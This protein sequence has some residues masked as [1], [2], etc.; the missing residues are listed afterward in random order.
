MATLASSVS[1]RFSLRRSVFGVRR[2]MI[3]STQMS[4]ITVHVT[5][6]LAQR[7]AGRQERLT[8]ILELGL[9]ELNAETQRGF[10]GAAE[11]LEFLAGLPSP[12]EILALRPSESFE[13]RVRE[14]LAKN[15]A[16]G[17]TQQEEEEW[18]RYEYLEHLVRMAKAKAALRLGQPV[19]NG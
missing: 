6:D 19:A 16:S 1:Y 10:V 18:D 17:L 4:A 9:R 2:R 12:Q 7:L 15:R 8:E 14:L 13:R 3:Y 5:D 11:V